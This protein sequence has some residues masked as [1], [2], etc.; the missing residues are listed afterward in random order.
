MAEHLSLIGGIVVRII[1]ILLVY[2]NFK[3]A[4]RGTTL[5]SPEVIV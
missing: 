5:Y 4:L 3:D 1:C 2:S